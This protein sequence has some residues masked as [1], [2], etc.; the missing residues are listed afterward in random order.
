MGILAKGTELK[1]VA[2]AGAR[3]RHTISHKINYLFF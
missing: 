2:A 3:K 1:W